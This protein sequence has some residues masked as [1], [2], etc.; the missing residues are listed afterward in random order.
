MKQKITNLLLLSIIFGVFATSY[1]ALNHQFRIVRVVSDSMAP[2][3]SRD[4]L[5]LVAS[6]KS[7]A[8][9][10]G[11]IAILP[12]LDDPEIF[13][14]HRIIQLD[15]AANGKLEVLTKGD[16]NPIADDRKIQILSSTTPIYLGS[17]PISQAPGLIQ[18]SLILLSALFV[19]FIILLIQKLIKGKED[20]H[21]K[22]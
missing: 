11:Q 21:A 19:I 5:I 14:A 10:V 18:N 1:V 9:K 13:Y 16:A 8:L 3:F 6:I 17:L 15:R 20:R 22:T 7:S 12:A 2:L 4:D